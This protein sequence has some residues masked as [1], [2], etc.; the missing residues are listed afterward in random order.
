[1]YYDDL[2]F[3]HKRLN[4]I[5]DISSENDLLLGNFTADRIAE[6]SKAKS[7]I[8]E[9]VKLTQNLLTETNKTASCFN[10]ILIYLRCN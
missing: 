7:D 2:E 4:A 3:L 6:I 1:M 5:K 9:Y 8:N 10:F